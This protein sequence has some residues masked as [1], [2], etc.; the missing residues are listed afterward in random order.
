[1]YRI[2]FG[3]SLL[4]ILACSDASPPEIHPEVP[5]PLRLVAGSYDLV[6]REL[7]SSTCRGMELDGLVGLPAELSGGNP[8]EMSVE[9]WEFSG[10]YRGGLLRL[11]GRPEHIDRPVIVTDETQTDDAPTDSDGAAAE[12]DCGSAEG[13]DEAAPGENDGDEGEDTRGE[14]DRP[15]CGTP[16]PAVLE[17]SLVLRPLSEDEAEGMLS[18]RVEGCAFNARVELQPARANRPGGDAPPPTEPDSGGG[19]SG[20]SC[21]GSSGGSGGREP[22]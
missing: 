8:V 21:G 11:Q 12:R 5:A 15:R 22:S 2:F 19:S 1:M 20:G 17:A 16:E 18:V 7:V 6:L 13:D 9:E 10:G 14:E 3:L 4:S